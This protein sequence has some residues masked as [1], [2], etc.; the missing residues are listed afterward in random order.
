MPC[1]SAPKKTKTR[2]R[3]G[4][5]FNAEGR[6]QLQGVAMV[7]GNL[8][9]AINNRCTQI[10]HASILKGLEDNLIADA[11]SISVRD[12]HAYLSIIH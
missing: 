9:I 2:L 10:E 11:V 4:L 1:S 6:L 3:A 8:R 5:A 12:G 7:G